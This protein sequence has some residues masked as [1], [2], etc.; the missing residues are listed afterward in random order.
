[1]YTHITVSRLPRIPCN[2]GFC[3]VLVAEE[4]SYSPFLGLIVTC[5]PR[6]QCPQQSVNA[7]CRHCAVQSTCS[8]RTLEITSLKQAQTGLTVTDGLTRCNG[9]VH[10]AA[11]C[12]QWGA[13]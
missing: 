1:M 8:A 2:K 7:V 4:D 6:M 12:G 11:S 10:N 13:A 5:L 9:T 3:T